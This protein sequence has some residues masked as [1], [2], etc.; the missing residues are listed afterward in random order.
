MFAK[1]ERAAFLK[2]GTHGC[3]LGGNPICAAVAA[4]VFDVME[5]EK[6][7]EGAVKLGALAMDRIRNFRNA[8][9]RIKDVRGRGLMLGIELTV[10][11]A[12]PVV[13]EALS[14]GVVINAT[15]KNV[16]RLA[17]ALTIPEPALQQGLDLLE[18]AI[19]AG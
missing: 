3:T 7:P 2:P 6:L 1:P 5:K 18:Q 15:H 13:K 10:T 8:G 11:D 14:R 9:Q 17:P 12:A 16:I 4:K 19:N